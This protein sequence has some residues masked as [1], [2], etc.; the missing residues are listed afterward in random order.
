MTGIEEIRKKQAQ[1]AA[2]IKSL[3]RHI[4]TLENKIKYQDE[5][6]NEQKAQ[7][8]EQREHLQSLAAQLSIQ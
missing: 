7:L 5:L 6:I 3:N 1:D 2:L 8:K 4:A